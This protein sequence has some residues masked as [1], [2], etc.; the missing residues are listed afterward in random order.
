M[1]KKPFNQTNIRKELNEILKH[2]EIINSEQLHRRVLMTANNRNISEI[3]REE[4]EELVMEMRKQ[5]SERKELET[6]FKSL[7]TIASAK[8]KAYESGLKDQNLD[9]IIPPSALMPDYGDP[10]SFSFQ[11]KFNPKTAGSYNPY[12]GANRRIVTLRHKI[13][14]LQEKIIATN[15]DEQELRIELERLRK[16]LENRP[17]PKSEPF[18]HEKPIPKTKGKKKTVT[19]ASCA[20]YCRELIKEE[21]DPMWHDKELC[22]YYLLTKDDALAFELFERLFRASL[23]DFDLDDLDEMIKDRE[24]QVA[25]LL[26]QLRHLEARKQSLEGPFRD[27]IKR[28]PGHQLD[29]S[30]KLEHY[31]QRIEE[32]NKKIASID[33]INALI[34]QLRKRLN[35]LLQ[36]KEKAFDEGNDRLA[37]VD[38]DMRDKLNQ[39]SAE[40]AGVEQEY[41]HLEERDGRLRERYETIIMELEKMKKDEEDLR[42]LIEEMQRKKKKTHDKFVMLQKAGLQYPTEIRELY[43]LSKETYPL[44]LAHQ[45]QEIIDECNQKSKELRILKKRCIA[46]RNRIY[47]QH[48]RISTYKTRINQIVQDYSNQYSDGTEEY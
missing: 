21:K 14:D 43:K 46:L 33:D 36:E 28:L 47:D 34:E 31:R 18:R 9:Y 11:R 3:T 25:I 13:G 44:D 1:T 17:L 39:I 4:L 6:E 42:R 48:D 23:P 35:E 45:R 22:V 37:G 20:K 24:A 32:L 41:R 12:Q 10:T 26:E 16:L 7:L 5:L 2:T 38:K 40:K 15:K 30:E 29:T 27:L 8:V 19:L